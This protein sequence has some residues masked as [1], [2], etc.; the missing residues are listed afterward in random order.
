MKPLPPSLKLNDLRRDK[1]ALARALV[2]SLSPSQERLLN[3]VAHGGGVYGG[4]GFR[5]IVVSTPQKSELVEGGMADVEALVRHG[6]MRFA[7][8]T[9]EGSGWY[10]LTASSARVWNILKK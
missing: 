2:A 5:H 9:L 7:R 8:Q 1:Q 6:W 3:V 4:A 10:W